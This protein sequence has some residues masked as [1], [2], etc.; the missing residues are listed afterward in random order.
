VGVTEYDDSVTPTGVEDELVPDP[1]GEEQGP[2][3]EG[4]RRGRSPGASAGVEVWARPGVADCCAKT[5]EECPVSAA[6]WFVE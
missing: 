2:G 1:L 3:S 4:V 6:C 5:E